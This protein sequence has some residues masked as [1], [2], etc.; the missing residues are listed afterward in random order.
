MADFYSG[1]LA[2]PNGFAKFRLHFAINIIS[3]DVN[4]NTST[5]AWSTTLEKDRSQTGFYNYA[6][7]TWAAAINGTTVSSGSG[8]VPSAPWAGWSGWAIGSGTIVVAHNSDG[9]KTGVPVSASYSGS[10]TGWSIG[11]V[12]LSAT[13]DLPTIARATTPAVAPSPAPVG[14]TVTITLPR[15]SSGFTHDVTWVSGALSGTI[16]TGLG[17][18]TMWTV[19]DVMSEFPG[20]ARAPITIT[21][22]TKSG[23]A[24]I[25]SRQAT[26]LAVEPPAPPTIVPRTPETQ[27]DIRARVVKFVDDEW[28][29]F[30]QIPADSIQLVDPASATATCTVSLSK[31]NAVDFEDNSI[32]DIDVFNGVDWVYT[33]HRFVL[34]RSSDDSVDPTKEATYTGT[35][36]IDYDLGFAFTQK[37]YE[38]TGVTAGTILSTL[39]ADSKAYGWG[40][41][42][43]F[44]FTAALTALGDTWSNTFDR[45]VGKGTALSQVLEGLVTDGLVEYRTEYHGNKA[46]LSLLNPGTGADFSAEGSSPVVNFTLATLSRAPRR[47]TGE[48]RITR[49]TVD[50]D[51][52]VQVTRQQASFDPDVFGVMEGWVSASGVTTNDAANLIGDNALRDNGSVTTER[53]FEYSA[54]NAEAHLQPYAVFRPGDWVKIPSD[55]GPITD[56]VSQITVDKSRDSTTLTVLT[57]D[58][59]L[60]GQA[61]LAKR[62]AAQT[63]GTIPGG[64]QTTP[65]PLDSRIPAAPV[66]NSVTSAGYWNSDGA[67]KSAVTITW[68]AITEALNGATL[69]VDLYE[70][71]W[72]PALEGGEWSLRGSTD[73]LTITMNGWD[74]LDD[75]EFRV[76]GRSAAGIYG[77]FSEDQE[78]TTL[79]PAV[80]LDGPQIADLYTDG[81]GNIYIVWAGI[82]GTDP[83]PARLAY[84]VA[85]VSTDDGATYTTTGTPIAGAG[86]IVLNMNGVW[87]DYLVRLRGY[88]R[89]GNAGDASDPSTITLTDPHIDPVKPVAPT[90]LTATAGAAWS[91]SGFLPEAWFDLAWTAPTLDVDG[92]AI[93]IVGYDVYGLRAG[94]TVE[95]F[96]TTS[97]TNGVRV[98]VGNGETWTFRVSAAS[99]FGAVSAESD[100]ATATADAT[101][102]TAAAPTAPVL[103]QYAGLL[104]VKWSGGGMLPQIKYVYATIS[105]SPTGTFTRAGM[106]LVGAGEVVVPGLATEQ[107]YY[108]KI[109]MVDEL[110]NVS[111]SP[112]SDGLTLDPITGVTIQTSPVANTGIKMTSGALT[113]YDASGNPTFILNSATGEV[114]IA[115]YDAVFDLGA[116]GVVATTGAPTTG[117]ALSSESSSFNT[118]IHPSGVEIRNDQTPLS[119]W[120][121]DADDA[122]LVNFFSP[123]A[124][125]GQRL[126]V[127]EYEM[128]KEAKGTGSRLVTRY[129]GA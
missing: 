56:R 48:K 108:A 43:D 8:T 25:G 28:A 107:T 11:T 17:T 60:S 6:G 76:R 106:P 70:V 113:A 5:L 32:V 40:P 104:R 57:G 118:F 75:V 115:P 85:E 74:V 114:W 94:E 126:R 120:E 10:N 79:A 69:P 46:W 12:S 59:I 77:E 7:A 90:D 62:Q 67:A 71:W 78:H 98:P 112:V 87:G 49:V 52:T 84:V 55:D 89:L 19:P 102:S 117:I 33:G 116:S 82:L 73:Q 36:F 58:R 30:G 53:T 31:L 38:W 37:D 27:F 39:L 100:A 128:L 54:Q 47:S 80:D 103:D 101:I 13:M 99:N 91:A 21:A 4:A 22:I 86:T 50:G 124:V 18:S 96:L 1:W 93:E 105:T 97:A 127:G 41:R 16:G 14:S 81:V 109:V 83:A 122:S 44:A 45:K 64:N 68:A 34:S 119:W 26:L 23:G 42:I 92:N 51:D 15:A 63:G 129:R 65:S 88:D 121:A 125:I 123:R 66:I 72:R 20:A 2:P 35:E 111:T 29:A 110:G 3:Q 24:S 9:T 95:R 61:S